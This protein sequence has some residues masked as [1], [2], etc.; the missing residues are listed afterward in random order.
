MGS[1]KMR[2]PISL[3]VWGV[4]AALFL[5]GEVMQAAD[6]PA[7]YKL[8]YEQNFEKASAL[9]D[10]VF[11]DPAVWRFSTNRGNSSLELFGQSK[12]IPKHRSPFNIALLADKVLGDFI[13]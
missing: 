7:G 1:M 5:A 3:S 11:S 10:F 6:L 2:N 8:L 4:I 12:Y 9:Q 13:L